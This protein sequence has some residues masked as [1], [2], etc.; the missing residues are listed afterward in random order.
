[1]ANLQNFLNDK[2]KL[3]SP[4]AIAL[5]ILDAVRK[6]DDSFDELA[7]I[8]KTDPA[9]TARILKLANSSFYRLP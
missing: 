8:I 7:K 2:I 5:K 6:D 9:L 1:V 4:P 3:P